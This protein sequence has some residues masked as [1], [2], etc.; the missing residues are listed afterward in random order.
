MAMAIDGLEG[1]VR[2]LP[3]LRVGVTGHRPARLGN[4]D[5]PALRRRVCEVLAAISRAADGAQLTVISPL[6]EGADRVV[7]RAAID[8]GY[9]LRCVLPFA[10]DDYA[11]DFPTAA[12][13]AEF[14]ALMQLAAGVVEL[15]GLH[16]TPQERDAG[17]SAAGVYTVRHA[18]V[19]IAIW[20]GRQARG[21]GGTGDVVA[22]AL[23]SGIP[24]VWIAAAAPHLAQVISGNGAGVPDCRALD[25]L[26]ALLRR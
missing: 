15:D 12:S 25:E 2:Q 9:A 20:D 16:G 10:R 23:A 26:P 18:D 5:F 13:R 21:N 3:I 8:S 14:A 6:A 24:V 11:R 1:A 7:A 17:Y 19:M 22:L 4:A